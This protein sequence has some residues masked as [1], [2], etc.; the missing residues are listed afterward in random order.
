M[1]GGSEEE[2]TATGG[3]CKVWLDPIRDQWEA[4]HFICRANGGSDSPPNVR[5]M[6]LD[7]HAKKTST[8]I[9][10]ISKGKRQSNRHF[11][12]ERRG[13]GWRR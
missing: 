11:G 7:C 13:G 1:C 9:P 4:E 5:P 3:A 8:D 10:L 2:A 6:C 12:I